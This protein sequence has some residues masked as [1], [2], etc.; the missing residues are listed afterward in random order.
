MAVAEAPQPTIEAVAIVDDDPTGALAMRDSVL[1]A[2]FAPEVLDLDFHDLDDMVGKVTAAGQAAVF[3]HRLTYGGH[4][5]FT[6]AE[7]VA[8]L[9]AHRFPALLVTTFT[10]DADVSIRLVRDR[11]PVLLERRAVRGESIREGIVRAA[12]ELWTGPDEA[13]VPRRVLVRIADVSTE[14]GRDVVD[15]VIPSW[16]PNDAIRFPVD[17]LPGW[18]HNGTEDLRGVRFFAEVNI[19][20][21]TRDDVYLRSFEAAAEPDAEDGLA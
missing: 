8:E 15:A 9:Y 4:V 20:A 12:A 11:V 17:L 13:R 19:G 5:P 1:D 18:A 10:M 2:G 7:A 14:G 21:P 16:D 3:D 6:G